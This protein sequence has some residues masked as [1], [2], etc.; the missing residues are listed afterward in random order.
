MFF[1]TFYCRGVPHSP[2]LKL[3]TMY[4]DNYKK[5]KLERVSSH[6]EKMG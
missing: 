5:G 3:K 1:E 4:R 2:L 6:D